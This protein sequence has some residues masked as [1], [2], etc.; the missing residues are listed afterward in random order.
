M[1]LSMTGSSGSSLMSL[2]TLWF[3]LVAMLWFDCAIFLMAFFNG[4]CLCEIDKW[5]T[6]RRISPQSSPAVLLFIG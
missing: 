6:P 3:S 5:I 2:L 4:A 1:I